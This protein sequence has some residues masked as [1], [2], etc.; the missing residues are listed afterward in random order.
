VSICSRLQRPEAPIEIRALAAT[1]A[2]AF[3]RLRLEALERE[4]RAF[5]ESAEEHR[6]TSIEVVSAR[7]AERRTGNFVLGAFFAGQLVGIIGFSRDTRL[8]RRHKGRV[9]G[10]YVTEGHRAFGIGQQLLSELV[11]RARS[12]PGLEQIIL[13]VGQHQAVAKRLYASLGFQLFAEEKHALKI[14][15]AYVDEDYM[16]LYLNHE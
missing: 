16:V 6:A 4:P 5:A 7:L 2:D 8:K 9:W 10:V 12:E 13:T 14:G 1:D 15:D 11:G 3:W